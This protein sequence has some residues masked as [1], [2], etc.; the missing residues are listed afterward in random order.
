MA[1]SN[2]TTAIKKQGLI[3]AVLILLTSLVYWQTTKYGFVAYDDDTYI[4]DNP[5]VQAGLTFK[6]TAWAF[7]STQTGNWH[8]M[9]WLSHMLD[10]EI[11][12]LNPGSHHLTSLFLHLINTLLLYMIL[13]NMT[14]AVWRSCFVAAL[15]ALHPLHVESVVWL[16]ERK[17]LLSTF[18]WMLTIAGYIWY[19]KCPSLVRY[20]PVF[21]FFLLGLMAKPMLVT[22]PFVLLLLD[23]W[24]LGRLKSW[25]LNTKC[26]GR[27]TKKS[28]LPP[29]KN[30]KTDRHN[31]FIFS[32]IL[33]KSPLF[34]LSAASCIVTF[35]VQKKAGAVGS[36]EVFPFSVRFANAVVSYCSYIAKMLW[37]SNLTVFYPHPEKI[38]WGF[39]AFSVVLLLALSTAAVHYARQ[40]PY[41][42]VGW[43]WYLGTLLP[44]VGLVQ[45]GMQGRADR[46]TYIPL[47]GIFIIIAWAIPELTARLRYQQ[48]LLGASA[49]GIILLI[50]AQTWQQAGY[51]KDSTTL[52]EHTLA[53]TD[54]N[55]MAH[56]NYGLVLLWQGKYADA[57]KHINDALRI[58]PNYALSHYNLGFLYAKQ[59]NINEALQHFYRAVRLNPRN[60]VFRNGLG[61]AFLRQGRLDE[62]IKQFEASVQIKP[63]YAAAW[64]N[65]G[66]ALA[67]K[68]EIDDALTCYNEAVLLK[69]DFA[70]AHNNLGY[71]LINKKRLDEAISHIQEALRL[72]PAFHEA[73]NNMG[74][75]LMNQG[76]PKEAIEGFRAALRLK[77]D[78]PLA[79]T[80]L[81]NALKNQRNASN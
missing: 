67:G 40:K 4:Q 43:L 16:S 65:R 12:G 74:V 45:V 51:W 22:L 26:S 8:P 31:A 7:T 81:N 25:K 14:G 75:A 10:V 76:R 30:C 52:F 56:N 38:Q 41:M 57:F 36:L 34:F 35:L 70:E 20:L 59:G 19:V 28:K 58:K 24:P 49:I 32:L 42:L 9:T 53:I 50:S 33:E 69:P 46:Y 18:F 63:A 17:D 44:V 23:V 77:S 11:Y 64:F 62:A 68:G 73:Y 2:K 79:Q 3:C 60:E 21:L 13:K 29:Q 48:E 27:N 55:Y 15:F 39:L 1:I 78:Y 6:G 80:N 71:V 47:I 37:P 5:Y 61:E 66:L 72:K 54:N